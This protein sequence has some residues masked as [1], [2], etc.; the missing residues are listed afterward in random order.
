MKMY[1]L[2]HAELELEGNSIALQ[3]GSLR[4]Q[5]QMFLHILC[6][7]DSRHQKLIIESQPSIS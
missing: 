3:I 1:S 6:K 5:P 2:P 7:K 4:R